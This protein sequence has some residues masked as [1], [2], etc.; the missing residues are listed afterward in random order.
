[1]GHLCARCFSRSERPCPEAQH[2]NAGL[3]RSRNAQLAG[4]TGPTDSADASTMAVWY[5]MP[6][7]IQSRSMLCEA[8]WGE[9]GKVDLPGNWHPA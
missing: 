5:S 8:T 9:M 3:Q 2:T 6:S 4:S 1:M 7:V